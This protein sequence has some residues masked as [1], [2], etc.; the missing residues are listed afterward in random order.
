MCRHDANDAMM[1]G[2]GGQLGTCLAHGSTLP[3]LILLFSPGFGCSA[4]GVNALL[5]VHM[6]MLALL[7]GDVSGD[8]V[9]DLVVALNGYIQY[10]SSAT[11]E[12]LLVDVT[13][14]R[15]WIQPQG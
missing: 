12:P 11:G 5:R 2:G 7:A 10:H 1:M 14:I 9:P 15:V 13:S 8:Q 3:H 4:C 6:A